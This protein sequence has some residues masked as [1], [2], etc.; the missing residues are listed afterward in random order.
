[1]LKKAVC[2]QGSGAERR[3]GG[4]SRGRSAGTYTPPKRSVECAD[5]PTVP[6]IPFVRARAAAEAPPRLCQGVSR[7]GTEY[8][9]RVPAGELGPYA[10]DRARVDQSQRKKDLAVWDVEK[11]VW[12]VPHGTFTLRAGSSSRD[13]H[14]STELEITK[15]R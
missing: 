5:R 9:R 7:A 3:Q 10:A 12:F 15:T 8:Q 2:R 4:R 13:L 14:L 6:L 11:Q 1:M